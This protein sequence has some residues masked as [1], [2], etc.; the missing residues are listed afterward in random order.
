M[1]RRIATNA[2]RVPEGPSE[3]SIPYLWEPR[4]YQVDLLKAMP[5]NKLGTP[6][7]TRNRFVLVWPRRSGKDLTCLSLTIREMSMRIGT[8][9]H[10]FPT[11]RQGKRIMWDGKDGGKGIPFLNRF[12]PKMILSKNET[13]LQI[14]MKPFPGQP[15]YGEPGAQGSTWQVLGADDRN[16]LRGLGGVGVVFSEFSEMDEFVWQEIFEPIIRETKGWAIFN[17]TPKGQN[18]SYRLFEM[19]KKNPDIWFHQHLTSNDIFKD[20]TGE[21]GTLVNPPED[22]EQMRKEGVPEAIIAQE[23]MCSFTG[24]LRGTIFGDLVT[25][26]RNSGRVTRVLHDSNYPVGTCW[27]IGRTDST[28]IWFYQRIGTEIRFIDYLE[29][30]LQG[31]DYYARKLREKPYLISRLILP[32]DARVKGYTA[33]HST[34]EFFQRVFRGVRVAEKISVQSGIDMTRRLFSRF[35]FS[36]ERCA[37]GIECL[38]QYRRKWDDE[39]HDYSGDPIHNEFSHGVDALRTGVQGGLDSPLDFME[40]NPRR[41]PQM[42][43][44]D[45]NVFERVQ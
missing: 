10:L 39:K 42:A 24:F 43:E 27:D 13:E 8:Y 14:V 16:T 30:S 15:G 11:F 44:T 2:Q 41:N 37:R 31:A 23:Y 19:A 5:A 40:D 17:F 1:A 28:A 32:H 3:F 26:A 38:E 7:K 6:R 4:S 18:H 29:D 21:D 20:A 12:P 36:D 25:Q 35:V 45:F 22:L 9:Y 33:E 34:E